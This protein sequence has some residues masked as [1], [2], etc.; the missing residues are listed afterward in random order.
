MPEKKKSDDINWFG[1]RVG[2]NNAMMGDRSGAGGIGKYLKESGGKR[3]PDEALTDHERS[4]GQE[5]K[6]KPKIG[7][8]DFDAW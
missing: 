5:R 7:F 1:V 4:D 2:T 8:S 6:K 3:R